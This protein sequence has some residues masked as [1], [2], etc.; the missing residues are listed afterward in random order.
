MIT[1]LIGNKI[2]IALG[3]REFVPVLHSPIWLCKVAR[4][5]SEDE[6]AP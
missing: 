1:K 3:E 5:S 2:S 6:L 4:I